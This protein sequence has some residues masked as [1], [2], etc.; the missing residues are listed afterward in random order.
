M[1]AAALSWALALLAAPTAAQMPD[2]FALIDGAG[3]FIAAGDM[4]GAWRHLD[5]GIRAARRLGPLTP[6]WSIALAM[7]ADSIRNRGDNPAYALLIPEEGLALARAGG[8]AHAQEAALLEVSRAYALADLGRLDEAAAV[9]AAPTLGALFGAGAEAD[10]RADAATWAG[11]DLGA[12]NTSALVLARR[13]L[14]AAEAAL[15]RRDPLAALTEAARAELPEGAGFPEAE[16]RLLRAEARALTGRALVLSGRAAEAAAA[17][18]EGAAALLAP[19]WQAGGPPVWQVEVPQP[20]RARLTELF[21]WRARA[22]IAA[23]EDGVALAALALAEGLNDRADWRVTLLLPQVQVA[24]RRG[25]EAGAD[26]ILA[27]AGAAA[28]ARGDADMALL[29]AFYRAANQAAMAPTW[30]AVDAPRLIAVARAAAQAGA[31]GDS[32]IDPAFVLTEAAAGLPAALMPAEVLAL[33]REAAALS[34]PGA[35]ATAAARAQLRKRAEAHLAA[36]HALDAARPGAICPD[37][38]GRGCALILQAPEP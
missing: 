10:L 33:T 19:G 28:E 13:A 1:R 5:R 18:D 7:L 4:D 21:F 12:L 16:L 27:R 24:Q 14:D 3:P 22:A 29:V 32:V 9:L 35:P 6:D 31:R 36:A 37:E 30:E 11:G 15:D 38:P 25:D 8:A 34:P 17:L 26:A 23:G 2:P 20:S